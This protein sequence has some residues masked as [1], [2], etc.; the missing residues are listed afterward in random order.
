V[1]SVVCRLRVFVKQCLQWI[2]RNRFFDIHFKE[3]HRKKSLPHNISTQKKIKTSL[4]HFFKLK[5]NHI[6]RKENSRAP[7]LQKKEYF[8]KGKYFSLS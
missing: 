4:T 6:L 7:E 5:K 2:L 1:G 3:F 8:D